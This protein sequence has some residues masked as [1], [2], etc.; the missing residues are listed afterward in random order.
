[1]NISIYP[2]TK[3]YIACPAKTVTGGPELLHQLCFHIR[4]ELRTDSYM[5]YLPEN[6]ENPMP[7]EYKVY[8]CKATID[9]Q[10]EEKNILIV[11][12]LI[13][14]INFLSRFKKIRKIIWWLSI[15]NFFKSYIFNKSTK[16]L[17][18]LKYKIFQKINN[19]LKIRLFNLDLSDRDFNRIKNK[20]FKKI[21]FLN[22]IDSHFVQSHYAKSQLIKFGIPDK[23]ICY[24][25][26]YINKKYLNLN[27]DIG[28]KENVLVYNPS[29]GY[30][31]THKI[32]KNIKDLKIFPIKNLP[33][34]EVIALLLKAKVYIDFGNHPGKD[35]IPREAA[36]L[37]CCIIVGKKG[38]ACY[39][40]DVPIPEEYK[41]ETKTKNIHEIINKISDCI[42]NYEYKIN[43]FDSYR[44]FIKNE[45][46]TFTNDLNKI[47][48]LKK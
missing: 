37:G 22:N 25:S 2:D 16:S 18:S 39:N 1:M 10:D 30:K 7:D 44:K 46:Y 43:D 27:Y 26:D 5:Y 12:E 32:I 15:D 41:F 23:K 47:F 4:N 34:D 6:T 35:R 13:W 33:Q 31:F 29:K 9:I 45:P 36:T 19:F 24:L 20:L 28:K 11:P 48:I 38:S 17:I 8:D 21:I 40:E 14:T 42:K 3:I